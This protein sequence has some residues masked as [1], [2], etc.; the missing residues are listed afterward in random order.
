M[1]ALDASASRIAQ[2]SSDL[3]IGLQ[4]SADAVQADVQNLTTS[5]SALRDQLNNQYTALTKS[6]GDSVTQINGYTSTIV[7]AAADLQKGIGEL[8]GAYS[9]GKQSIETI[10]QDLRRVGTDIGAIDEI[11]GDL[12]RILR[13]R[14]TAFDTASE[15]RE[16]AI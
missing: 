9:N 14:I 16:R 7:R 12:V 15:Q 3:E 4:Q 8:T 10:I 11:T 5:F 2:I 13:E 1:T 6:I